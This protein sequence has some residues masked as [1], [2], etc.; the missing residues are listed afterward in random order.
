MYDH[1]GA[2]GYWAMAALAFAGGA[3]ALFI[4]PP[5]PPQPVATL[6]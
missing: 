1:I 4:P 5:P 3:L 6:R 2:K